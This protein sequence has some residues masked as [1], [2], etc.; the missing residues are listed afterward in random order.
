MLGSISA[1]AL[2]RNSSKDNVVFLNHD[3]LLPQSNMW[4]DQHCRWN[5]LVL[6]KNA[7]QR[8]SHLKTSST[9]RWKNSVTVTVTTFMVKRIYL[10]KRNQ[11]P[12]FFLQSKQHQMKYS[13]THKTVDS[14]LE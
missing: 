7:N 8:L 13:K 14:S 3:A 5:R 11:E 9:A 10:K 6:E 12:H 1:E 4:N 2:P